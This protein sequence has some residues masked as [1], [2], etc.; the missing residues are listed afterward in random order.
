MLNPIA[1]FCVYWAEMLIAYT[2][3]SGIS[4]RR[5]TVGKCLLIGL[6]IYSAASALNLLS[7]NNMT[8]NACVSFGVSILFSL[9][10]FRSRPLRQI[11]CS[12]LL[13]LVGTAIESIVV[14]LSAYITGNDMLDYNHNFLLF[15]FEAISCK[16]LHYLTTLL[17]IKIINP[18]GSVARIPLTF[19]LYPIASTA[20]L[21]IFWRICAQPNCSRNS[22]L[23]LA[24]AAGGLFLSSV[25]LFITYARQSEKD[26][27]ALA[28]KSELSRLQTEQSYY[29]ILDQQNQQ[30][31]LYAHD[32]KK[33]LAAI[34]SLNDDPQI[35]TYVAKLS[36]QLMD[37][38]KNCHSGNKMLDVMIH[39]YSMDCEIRGIC[40]DYD[41]K[42]CN[43]SE[44][45]DVDLVAILGNL[46]DNAV[47]AAEKSEQK[48]ISLA[49]DRRN[50]YSVILLSNSCDIPPRSLGSQ[51]ITSDP[52]R[53]LHGFGMKSV[54]KT[55]KK[56]H[57]DFEWEYIPEKRLFTVTVMIG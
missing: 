37:Y 51:L 44:V 20:C 53:E 17:V 25:F 1:S 38:T 29:Q 49:T 18:R 16:G 41:I 52:D 23:L 46:I 45:E 21:I 30:L 15:I 24:I 32:A 7:R 19:F 26:S 50:S 40:F 31:M 43:L 22:Q 34:Q 39:R 8:L 9:F 6:L 27:E 14:S 55:L 5:S 12:I 33:H 47:T 36:Q 35:G 2:F 3:F 28:I 4:Q 56:Y 42:L 13:T 57:G 48:W 10:C 11:F 54:S